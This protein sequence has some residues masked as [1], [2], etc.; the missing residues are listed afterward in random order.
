MSSYFNT[1]L[2][3]PNFYIIDNNVCI[4]SNILIF[5]LLCVSSKMWKKKML[6]FLINSV[7]TVLLWY[8]D[9][10]QKI[11]GKSVLNIS[12]YVL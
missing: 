12:L 8:R 11:F 9:V 10:S 2:K 5:T 1:N 6:L 3:I 7:V 4:L